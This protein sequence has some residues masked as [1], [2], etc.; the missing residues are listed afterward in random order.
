M[1]YD[2]FFAHGITKETIGF[3]NDDGSDRVLYKFLIQGGSA[4]R[5]PKQFST[6]IHYPRW[7]GD[8]NR[9]VFTI[10]DV[11]PNIRMINQY[12]LMHGGG[13]VDFDQAGSALGFDGDG[14][15]IIWIFK[16]NTKNE[17]QENKLREDK[18][19]LARLDIEK[20]ELLEEFYI[21]VSEKYW[22]YGVSISDDNVLT[23]MVLN[24]EKNQYEPNEEPYRILIYDIDADEK[25]MFPGYHPSLS[26]DGTQLAYYGYD[27]SIRIK[28]LANG[29]EL[30]L[31]YPFEYS[32]GFQYISR[33]GWS[34]DQKWL[35]YNNKDGEIFKINIITLEKMYITEG[36]APDWK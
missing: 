11:S 17:E 6:Y 13:C 27:G 8:G 18:S 29:E 24:T 25:T 15:I 36:F 2:P 16:L 32:N 12:G 7:S 33:P 19:F 14:N 23:A 31:D 5:A 20:C 22:L 3:V 34:P 21:P 35:V 30:V 4:F 1:P 9:L 28:T 26:E 10:T